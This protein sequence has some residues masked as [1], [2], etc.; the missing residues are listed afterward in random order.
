MM[1]SLPL[2]KS[3]SQAHEDKDVTKDPDTWHVFDHASDW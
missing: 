2:L 3:K 1:F